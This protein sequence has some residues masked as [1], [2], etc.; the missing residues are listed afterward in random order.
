MQ[1]YQEQV[2]LTKKQETSERPQRFMGVAKKKPLL[3][4]T[5]N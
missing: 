1:N 5:H 4:K 3:K 2:V